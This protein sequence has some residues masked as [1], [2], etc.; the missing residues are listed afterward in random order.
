MVFFDPLLGVGLRESWVG[1]RVLEMSDFSLGALS[2]GSVCDG[3]RRKD[4]AEGLRQVAA[5]AETIGFTL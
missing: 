3:L 1:L 4:A 2:I 5:E